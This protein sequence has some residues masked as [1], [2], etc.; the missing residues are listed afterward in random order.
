[1]PGP[2]GV[3]KTYTEANLE[4]FLAE[5]PDARQILADIGVPLP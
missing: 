3:A 4:E 5:V 2:D 1:M